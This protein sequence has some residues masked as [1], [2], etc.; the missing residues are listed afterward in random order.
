MGEA[1]IASARLGRIDELEAYLARALATEAAAEAFSQQVSAIAPACAQLMQA[2][3]RD[4]AER[5]WRWLSAV[6]LARVNPGARARVERVRGFRATRLGDVHEAYLR[7][8]Q[9]LDASDAV[10]DERHGSVDRVNVGFAASELGAYAEAHEVLVAALE[11]ARR[12]GLA[13]VEMYAHLN[14]AHVLWRL[15]RFAESRAAAARAL[16]DAL[17]QGSP[18]AAGAARLH[19]AHVALS[20]GK[21]DEAEAEAQRAVDILGVAPGLRAAALAAIARARL[22]RGDAEGA[23]APAREAV[24]TLDAGTSEMFE[25]LVRATLVDVLAA[26]RDPGAANALASAH[27]A[28]LRFAGGISNPTARRAFLRDVPEH[29]HLLD[30]A[31]AAGLGEPT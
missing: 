5:L 12:Y 24:T 25:G 13:E 27:A 3:R 9:A 30:L 22:A 28:V 15:G 6:Q 2:G 17:V 7:H 19:V 23:V 20:E 8:Q 26:A 18:R 4:A 14:L 21:L 10:G 11:R 31:A 29:A 16:R 1:V